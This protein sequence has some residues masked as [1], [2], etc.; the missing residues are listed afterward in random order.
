MKVLKNMAT[1]IVG[2]S[3]KFMTIWGVRPLIANGWVGIK[4]Q[5]SVFHAYRAL[6]TKRMRCKLER[7]VTLNQRL[8]FLS[9]KQMLSLSFAISNWKQFQLFF[10]GQGHQ[11]VSSRYEADYLP[12][13]SYHRL[14]YHLSFNE[15]TGM[16]ASCLLNFCK[17]ILSGCALR[18]KSSDNILRQET[19]DFSEL[20][21]RE[22]HRV[23][24]IF[25]KN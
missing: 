11:R 24:F 25:D 10:W 17:N 21:L 13:S 1:L 16:K 5:P 8:S 3:H 6:A 19:A 12:P 7:Y 20:A 23:W 18:A 22:E 2:Y 9:S 14:L 4:I 15:Y